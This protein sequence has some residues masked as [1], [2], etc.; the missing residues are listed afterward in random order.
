MSQ[1]LQLHVTP[2]SN[3]AIHCFLLLINIYYFEHLVSEHCTVYY[4][5]L[6]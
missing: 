6:P 2:I 5:L 4:V 1:K 3:V